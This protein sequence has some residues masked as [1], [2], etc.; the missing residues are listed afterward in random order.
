MKKLS[1]GGLGLAL[2]LALAACGGGSSHPAVAQGGVAGTHHSVGT[3]VSTRQISGLGTVLVDAQGMT[4]YAFAPDHAKRVTCTGSCASIW[5]PLKLSGKPS[6][7]SGT[8]MSLLG[9]DTD[10]AG[11]KVVTYNGWPLYTYVGDTSPGQAN[12]Q[13][14]NVNGGLWAVVSPAG[15]VIHKAMHGSSGGSTTSGGGG[16]S[17][18]G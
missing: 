7:G 17:T 3:T 15:M 14:L 9:A 4:L 6:P 13:G 12:G 16:G 1:L 10:P 18:W 5:H 8:Q 2:V 11:G